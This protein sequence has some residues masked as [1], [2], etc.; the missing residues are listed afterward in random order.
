MEVAA[1][2]VGLG[3]AAG[4]TVQYVPGKGYEVGTGVEYVP[5]QGYIATHALP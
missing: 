5:G 3:G 1:R 4:E 2:P